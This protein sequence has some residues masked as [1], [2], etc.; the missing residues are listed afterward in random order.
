[1]IIIVTIISISA[2]SKDTTQ[3]KPSLMLSNSDCKKEC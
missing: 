3:E 1:M 2:G